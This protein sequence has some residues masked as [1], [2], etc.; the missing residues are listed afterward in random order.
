MAAYLDNEAMDEDLLSSDENEDNLEVD[1]DKDFIDDDTN[2][3]DQGPSN[4]RLTNVSLNYEKVLA[5]KNNREGFECSDP[6]N[7]VHNS[8]KELFT[9]EINDF[10]GW[11]K[12]LQA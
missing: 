6:E 2:F 11:E 7:Y 3:L 10:N 4:Y 9:P 1:S 12:F 5:D 8:C